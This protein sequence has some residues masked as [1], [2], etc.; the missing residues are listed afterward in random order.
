[1]GDNIK[2]FL[3]R[4][5]EE[6]L[7]HNRR[8][9]QLWDMATYYALIA[10]VSIIALVFLPMI[11]SELPLS[12]LL[13]STFAGWIVYISSKLL[14]AA[15]NMALFYCFMEQG[16]TNVKHYWHHV[17]ANELLHRI[18]ALSAIPRSPEIWKRGE[19]SF[20]GGT[21]TVTS[22]LSAFV[23]GHAVLSFDWIMF[24]SYFLTLIMGIVFGLI[25][26]KKSECYWAEEYYDYALYETELYN[27]KLEDPT[28]HLSVDE[29][30]KTILE[31]ETIIYDYNKQYAIPQFN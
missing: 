28:K 10:I 31:G 17:I 6:T 19:Y 4:S 2:E 27:N 24:L 18:K 23:L 1:M 8:Q 15:V 11:G 12:L 25:Q 30:N 3:N 7:A 26:M 21:I 14:V 29:Q 16:R 13:P 5:P 22:I 9:K 20:K